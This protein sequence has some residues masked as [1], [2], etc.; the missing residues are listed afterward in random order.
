[1]TGDSKL[2]SVRPK[3]EKKGYRACEY[4]VWLKGNWRSANGEHSG[5]NVILSQDGQFTINIDEIEDKA[6]PLYEGRMV[7]QFDFSEKGWVSG[8]GRSA[9]WREIPF[10]DKAIEPQYLMPQSDYS[11]RVKFPI[12][13]KLSFLDI[14]SSTN[15]RSMVSSTIYG[16]PCGHSLPVFYLSTDSLNLLN[17]S[18]VLNSFAYDFAL[19]C[20]LGGLHLSY[21]ILAETPIVNAQTSKEMEIFS[22][23]SARLSWG[24][25]RYADKWSQLLEGMPHSQL[26]NKVWQS[27]WALSAAER[28]RLRCITDALTAELYGLDWEDYAWVFNSCDVPRKRMNDKNFY[29]TLDPKG[30]WRVDK[31]KDPELRHTVLSLV[32][33]HDLKTKG[34]DAFLAQNEGEGWLLPT[35]LR[36]AD[37]GLGHDDR[38]RE[39][40]PVASRLGPRF[41]D[42]Q[43]AGTPA[44]SWAEC[45]RHAENLRLLLGDVGSD[46]FS[47]P[48]EPAKAVTTSVQEPKAAY[49]T[50]LLGEPVQT[51]L[52]GNVVNPTT[53][54]KR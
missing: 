53:K 52:F 4:G 49:Q 27:T 23:L 30:L 45:E 16:V 34:L 21:F 5:Q 37:Y 14:G 13:T 6:L 9:V 40:Q 50:N 41:L 7:G 29:R 26:K 42:W 38:A 43:L 20:R 28:L 25:V 1:M 19:R 3:W 17:L 22:T 8:K 10:G 12:A 36:L 51:D 35:T 47:R 24:H 44:E 15:A 54:R 18:A 46:D 31:E 32:A 33:F 2:F 39:P 11:E 48:E